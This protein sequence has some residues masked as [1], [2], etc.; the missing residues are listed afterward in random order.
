MALPYWR[1]SSFY[2]FFFASLGAIVPYWSLYLSSLG[3]D[4]VAIGQMM[5][6]VMAT[7]IV[8]PNV[9]GWLADH[10]GRRMSIVRMACFLAAVVFSGV[11]WGSGF[12]WLVWVMAL[13]SFFW[14]AA[15]P[16]FEAQTLS[17]LGDQHHRYS[18]IR[19]WG[20]VGFILAVVALGS[21]LE[22]FGISLLPW[23]VVTLFGALWLSSLV[24]PGGSVRQESRQSCS[25]LDILRRP[26]VMALF[27][28]CFLLQMSHGPYYTFFSIYLENFG[29]SRSQIGQ[30]WGLG[31]VA[32]VGVFLVMH[33]LLPRYG[34]LSLLF[35]SL[36]LATLRWLLIAWFVQW[37]PVIWGAQLL[38]AASFG[39]YHAVAI[40][41]I[42]KLFV[43]RHQGRGQAL[44]SSVS[45]GAGGALGSLF[46]GY[47]WSS[48][49]ASYSFVFG[50]FMSALAFVL[51]WLGLR[52]K[53]EL[54]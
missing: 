42:H 24:V 45:F 1:L 21:A 16:Q 2:F 23:V 6:V 31:V 39:I 17:A 20:S 5:A 33:R 43:G 53:A 26:A 28:V 10:T 18:Q 48:L 7:K 11:F 50:A 14:N 29:Y 46:S 25:I 15:L 4:A 27:A 38:H 36:G 8:A 54:K 19:L 22:R 30:L 35:W 51:A 40:Y 41:L 47:V 37:W 13:F 32:E 52:G 49:G 3:F 44:Y 9:W 12:W 34:A